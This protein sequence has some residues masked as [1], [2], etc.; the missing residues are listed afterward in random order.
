MVPGGKDELE[1]FTDKVGHNH[2][3][4]AV[5]DWVEDHRHELDIDGNYIT[6]DDL[7]VV[8]TRNLR[9]DG[10]RFSYDAV[11]EAF[12]AYEDYHGETQGKGRAGFQRYPI[13]RQNLRGLPKIQNGRQRGGI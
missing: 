13:Q 6:L 10:S 8:S 2:I 11:M 9:A 1:R 7:T 3:W 4:A 5:E 12:I